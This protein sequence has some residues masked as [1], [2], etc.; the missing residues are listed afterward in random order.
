MSPTWRS[1]RCGPTPTGGLPVSGPGARAARHVV[2]RDG[3]LE[4]GR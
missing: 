4:M 2:E 1:P 3:P